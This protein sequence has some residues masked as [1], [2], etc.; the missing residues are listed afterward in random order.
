MCPRYSRDKSHI[1]RFGLARVKQIWIRFDGKTRLTEV[2]EEEAV[3][4][5]ERM[6]EMMDLKEETGIY[7][8]GEERRVDWG[9]VV[10]LE[11]VKKDG[12]RGPESGRRRQEEEKQEPF[13]TRRRL[14][15]RTARQRSQDLRKARGRSLQ[16]GVGQCLGQS[17]RRRRTDKGKGKDAGK[18]WRD[19]TGK[20]QSDEKRDGVLLIMK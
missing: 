9:D 7:M 14:K 8:V 11:E 17:E 10:R 18:R 13:G 1:D 2:E 6:R 16:G 12:R 15:L 19:L 3:R 20:T 4:L 5:E